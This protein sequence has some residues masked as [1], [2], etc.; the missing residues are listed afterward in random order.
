M[1]CE[2]ISQEIIPHEHVW[3]ETYYGYECKC[4]AFMPDALLCTDEDDDYHYYRTCAT[5]GGEITDSESSCQ[6]DREDET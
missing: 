4:G 1:D 2:S 5:C 6:C 3:K